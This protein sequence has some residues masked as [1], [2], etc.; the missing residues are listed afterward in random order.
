MADKIKLMLSVA[1]FPVKDLLFVRNDDLVEIAQSIHNNNSKQSM[2]NAKA[3]MNKL[4]S[5]ILSDCSPSSLDEINLLLEKFHPYLFRRYF[6]ETAMN[7]NEIEHTLY[8]YYF[9][10]ISQ[11]TRALL[12]HRDGE[13]VFKYWK[14]ESDGHDDLLGDIWEAYT[15]LDKVHMFSILSRL[16]PLDL[17][18]ASY[19]I[20]NHLSN[21]Y[22]LDG[23]YQHINLVDA[24]LHDVLGHGVAENHMH[25][26]AAFTFTMLW[27]SCMNFNG[28]FKRSAV[29]KYLSNFKTSYTCKSVQ[30]K[31]YILT[32]QLI[33]LI[34]AHYID[35]NQ[36]VP[37]SK[38]ISN[39]MQS[40]AK[41]LLPSLFKEDGFTDVSDLKHCV[42]LLQKE[43]KKGEQEYG[44][45][46]MFGVFKEYRQ[47]KTYGENI[48]LHQVMKYR[49]QHSKEENKTSMNE[50]WCLFFRY[51]RIK[52]EFYQ[53]VN[54]SKAVRG[55]D[56][57]RGYFE[58]A[59]GG[60]DSKEKGYYLDM[61]RNLFQNQYLKKV[62]FRIS[63]ANRESTNRRNILKILNAY[64]KIL[65]EDFNV[66]QNIEVAFPRIGIVYHLI[67]QKDD[68]NKDFNK[69]EKD[70]SQLAYLYYGRIQ[71]QY[72]DKI[73]M[74]LNLRNRIPYL[75]NF[76]VGLDAASLENNTPIQVFASV[77]EAA[78]DSKKD[79]MLMVDRDGCLTKQ[80]SL[81]FTFHAGE[82]FRHLNSGLRRID[83][84]IDFCKFH[85][86]DRIG[87]GI[88]LGI[89]VENWVNENQ[90]VIIPRGEYLDNLLWT[91]G[92]YTRASDVN[93]KIYPYLQHK[94]HEVAK[95]ILFD[96]FDY[97]IS[98][99][100]LYE[101]YKRR[102]KPI[103]D[104]LIYENSPG[105]TDIIHLTKLY[106]DKNFLE[107]LMA[108]IYVR[109]TDMEK[110]ITIDMQRYVR[111]KVAMNGIV[112]EV[113]P[114]SNYAIGE[115]NS[116]YDN[117]FF[118][119]NNGND[120]DLP[121]TMISI[122]TDDPIVFNTNISNEIA[123]LYYGMLYR[124][125]GKSEALGW[126]EN[127]RKSGMD[128]SFIRDNV[129]NYD[130]LKQLDCLIAA[131]DDPY[132][133]EE[134]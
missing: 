58:R 54:Q 24:P 120:K 98:I 35:S 53:Q 7:D 60:F 19:Y 8:N 59:T 94:I 27:Q 125:I 36:I 25:A 51:I 111:H 131:L 28:D 90:K 129:S 62:E 14:H 48:F 126:I 29:G 112:V 114:S 33:R 66:E 40:H 46:W 15:E 134:C 82:D 34:L 74:V 84:V 133:C 9:H 72:M 128:T 123:Y 107:R 73:K 37:I 71:Q 21:P 122:N 132:Y 23:L 47:V 69:Y 79:R 1:F 18:I 39:T 115:I 45:D 87:H 86:G 65:I 85:S 127:V 6:S 61:L 121:N 3:F 81:F 130:Y 76:I 63:I 2:A 26:S 5:S 56:Y 95:S 11:F 78:R 118:Q 43:F 13:M 80:Q 44:N 96:A 93:Y 102:F 64:K 113:N 68:I 110:E 12:S 31:E 101:V 106:H 108:P 124:G 97:N 77:F 103:P 89:S 105:I 16:I 10:L 92:V 42:E 109:T 119:I 104:S 22:Q 38:W 30:I 17:F 75:S 20:S 88:A 4:Y 50:F 117:Q 99:E 55:L 32:A 52:N 70:N 116:I 100:M 57:F 91:W 67:K 41:L 49:S 83:E